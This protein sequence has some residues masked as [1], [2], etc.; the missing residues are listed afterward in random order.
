[1]AHYWIPETGNPLSEAKKVPPD[2]EFVYPEIH[3]PEGQISRVPDGPESGKNKI[4]L[5]V[6]W[7]AASTGPYGLGRR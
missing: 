2:W 4:G 5:T 6:G 7:I 1:M 3:D